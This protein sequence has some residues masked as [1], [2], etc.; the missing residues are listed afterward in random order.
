MSVTIT[1]GEREYIGETMADAQKAMRAGQREVKRLEKIA[2]ENRK[3]A[4]MRAES[5][6]YRVLSRKLAHEH[7]PCGW[8]FYATD[9]KYGPKVVRHS[10]C[11]YRPYHDVTLETEWGMAQSS[12]YGYIC[13]GHVWN[14]GGF[15]I[16][17][18]FRDN[19]RPDEPPTALAVGVCEDQVEF[20][21][22]PGITPA[23][24]AVDREIES[25]A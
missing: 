5:I 24:F 19:A 11:Q 15:S 12:H 6:G 20:V 17:V 22:L 25:A 9:S 2:A 13:D 4:Q 1:V 23:F 10:D 7:A 18:F 16:V 21:D 8:R 14:G 3:I